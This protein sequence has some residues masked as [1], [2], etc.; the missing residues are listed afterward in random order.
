M[1]TH[2]ISREGAG[3]GVAARVHALLQKKKKKKK[4]H[5]D[6]LTAGTPDVPSAGSSE[7]E[8]WLP[9][10]VWGGIPR[11]FP[12]RGG[13]EMNELRVICSGFETCAKGCV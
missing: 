2:G 8:R 10:W 4:K 1:G 7:R 3:G 6:R 12:D 13:T 11:V 5:R 9:A